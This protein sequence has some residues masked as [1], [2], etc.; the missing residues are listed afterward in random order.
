L[1]IQ[2]LNAKEYNTYRSCTKEKEIYAII[3]QHCK[4]IAC[5][6]LGTGPSWSLTPCLK[7]TAGE[8]KGNSPLLPKGVGRPALGA[9]GSRPRWWVVRVEIPTWFQDW[10]DAMHG[11]VKHTFLS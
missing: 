2:F 11:P 9:A 10:T 3:S 6:I 8:R 4:L 7:K 1:K 5:L